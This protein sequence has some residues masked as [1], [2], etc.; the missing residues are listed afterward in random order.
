MVIQAALLVAVRAQAEFDAVTATLPVPPPAM[1]FWLAGEMV[2][3]QPESCVTVN[4]W[5]PTV[6]VPKRA[7]P[8]LAA[9][10]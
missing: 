1:K 6:I 4:V 10:E 9:A 8:V 5:P 7:G 2:N 3:A